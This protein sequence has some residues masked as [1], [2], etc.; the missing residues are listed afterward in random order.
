MS[1]EMPGSCSP[2]KN[3]KWSCVDAVL[4]DAKLNF[5]L[6]GVASSIA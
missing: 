3:P 4:S 1:S 6:V 5:D 2:E